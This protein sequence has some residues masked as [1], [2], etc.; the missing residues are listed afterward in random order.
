MKYKII[1][2]HKQEVEDEVNIFLAN[3]WS[4]YGFLFA[5]GK[6]VLLEATE[7]EKQ[8]NKGLKGWYVKELSQTM[9]SR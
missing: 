4:L 5:T 1:S 2:G 9:I 3:G 7:E 8:K 6:K